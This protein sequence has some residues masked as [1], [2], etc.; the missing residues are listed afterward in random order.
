MWKWPGL[1]IPALPGRQKEWHTVSQCQHG[2]EAEIMGRQEDD[3]VILR[4][5][6]LITGYNAGEDRN[7]GGSI[8]GPS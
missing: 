7:A 1:L 5:V 6:Q 8:Q 4:E 2:E 3:E